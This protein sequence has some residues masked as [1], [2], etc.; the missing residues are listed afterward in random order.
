MIAQHIVSSALYS[1]GFSFLTKSSLVIFNKVMRTGHWKH[2]PIATFVVS[3]VPGMILTLF[4]SAATKHG[5]LGHAFAWPITFACVAVANP[6]WACWLCGIAC[7]QL[8]VESP[9]QEPSVASGG[10]VAEGP[11]SPPMAQGTSIDG[12]ADSH[13]VSM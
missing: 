6:R 13:V 8:L 3:A 4:M 9:A 7:P 1:L 5:W 10:A 12:D 2:L 11:L